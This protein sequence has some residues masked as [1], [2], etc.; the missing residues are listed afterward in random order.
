MVGEL[1]K[2]KKILK[3]SFRRQDTIVRRDNG[4]DPDPITIF[5]MQG[6]LPLSTLLHRPIPLTRLNCE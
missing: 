6:R 2:G 5:C 1:A 4:I 3:Y